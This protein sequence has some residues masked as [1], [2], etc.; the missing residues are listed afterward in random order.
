MRVLKNFSKKILITH[1]SNDLY[2]ASK[3]LISTIEILINNGFD[4][5]LFLPF[6]GP[7]NKMA[8]IKKTNLKVINLGIFRKKYFNLLGLIN[9]LFFII[10]STLYLNKYIKKNNIDLIYINTSTIISP[11]IAAKFNRK[12][13]IYHIHEIPNSSNIYSKILSIFL[14]N[15]S[16]DIIVVSK[17]VEKFWLS[18]K[19]NKKKI[20]LIY[21]GVKFEHIKKRKK[22]SNHIIFT[23]I[24]RIIPYKG[25][26]YL[27]RIVKKL[28]KFNSK[29][30]FYIIGDTYPGYEKYEESLKQYVK[31]NELENN[32]VF[33]GFKEDTNK[34]LKKSN[35]FIHTAVEP[36]P[37]PTVILESIIL[38]TPVIATKLGGSIEILNNGKGGLLIPSNNINVSTDLIIKYMEN[39]KEISKRKNNAK[40]HLL[41]FFSKKQ[42]D[43]KI[44]R[45][46]NN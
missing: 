5:H 4:I 1:S 10:K 42:F 25:H 16:S 31:D 34:Y 33:A 43:E 40:K 37:L 2:G 30:I 7:I 19:L 18:H 14:N 46:F 20:T 8:I 6:D 36:D 45:L 12:R 28:I 21:N 15:F 24:A 22:K 38:N 44:L 32:V 26:L 35:F 11:A 3:I 13:V 9:R 41:K 17:A 27:L 39:E 29:F 23:N